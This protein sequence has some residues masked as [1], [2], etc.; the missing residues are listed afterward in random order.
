MYTQEHFEDWKPT[1][2]TAPANNGT[3]QEAFRFGSGI[4]WREANFFAAKYKRMLVSGAE[5]V[6]PPLPSYC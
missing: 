5:G 6:K 4:P 2:G 1:N 3:K